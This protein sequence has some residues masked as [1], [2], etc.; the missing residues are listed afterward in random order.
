MTMHLTWP[1]ENVINPDTPANSWFHIGSNYCL[2][3]HGDPACSELCIFSDG[4]HH[5]ALEQSLEIFRCSNHLKS[6]FYCT[7]PPKVYLDWMKL[8]SIELGNLR[9]SRQ[10]D[11]LIGPEDLLSEL[12][13]VGRVAEYRVFAESTGN[14][15]LVSKGNPRN[16]SGIRDLIRTDLRLFIS[17]P[18]TEKAS[19]EVY[20]STIES[21][22]RHLDLPLE[23]IVALFSTP[24]RI[25]FG[26]L[27]H[28]REA[29]QAIADGWADLAIVY[30]HLALRYTR[31]FPELFD[32]VPLPLS[33]HNITTQYAIG[34]VNT[35][36]DLTKKLFDFF[37]QESVAESY[38]Y[39]GLNPL[40]D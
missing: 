13:H 20:R 28:H 30:S 11:I 38:R 21:M 32:Q 24:E 16:I 4:N 14:S 1:R 18:K 6:I 40:T 22:A 5:M 7:T 10:P 37:S 31:I 34:I 3:I 15:L 29:P 35:E 26:E 25:C 39:H 17:N 9:L 27:I 12:K 23:K 2:D 33:E 8:G 19:H 36:H